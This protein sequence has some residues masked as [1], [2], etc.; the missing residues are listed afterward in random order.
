MHPK[1]TM[2]PEPGIYVPHGIRGNVMMRRVSVGK[3]PGP[4][5]TLSPLKSGGWPDFTDGGQPGPGCMRRVSYELSG[6]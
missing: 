4:G 5:P 2:F 1:G 6:P 3:F